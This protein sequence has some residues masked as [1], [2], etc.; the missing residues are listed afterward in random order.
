MWDCHAHL[1]DESLSSDLKETLEQA[2]TSGVRA[3]VCVTENTEEAERLLHLQ[4]TSEIW[5][6][7][8]AAGLPTIFKCIGIHPTQAKLES[9][10]TLQRL[11]RENREKIC[12]IGECGLDFT[13]RVLGAQ[14]DEIKAT[15][16]AV[17]DA[18]IALARELDL[19]LNVHSRSA[20]HH[21]LD[22]LRRGGVHRAVLHAFDGRAH[23]A[24]MAAKEGFFFSIPPNIVRSS[25][26]A[27]LARRVPLESLLL[28]TDSP[29][30]APIAG[31]RNVPA[32]L[33]LACAAVAQM[34]S[35]S[36]ETV[37]EVT[38]RN[39]ASLFRRT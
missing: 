17:F 33:M 27:D 9:V 26:F 8:P 21:V 25:S 15:Q 1:L 39:A 11:V 22:Q 35:V 7:Q 12:G 18:Q 30:L 28:E 6:A 10:E 3:I 37:I 24:E 4:E 34:K 23:Y 13:P 31:E 20:G 2:Y 5:S 19:P 16:I 29:A 36:V 14:P 32:N 38:S